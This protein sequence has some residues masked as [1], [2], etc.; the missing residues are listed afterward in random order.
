MTSQSS[1]QVGLGRLFVIFLGLG[2][3]GFGGPV[4]HL[5]M[6][7][8][9]FVSKRQWLSDEAYAERLALCNFMPGPSS[10][11]MGMALGF[12]AQG[13]WGLC[14]AFLGFTLPSAVLMTAFAYGL[15]VVD[16]L[17][18]P[19][20]LLGIKLSVVAIV[21]HA[22]MG[23]ARS[24]CP[25]ARRAGIALAAMAAMIIVPDVR[26]QFAVLAAGAVLGLFFIPYTQQTDDTPSEKYAVSRL[27]P[28]AMCL[29]G[30]FVLL[31]GLPVLARAT[32][33]PLIDLFT[34]FYRVGSLVFG[35]G[36]VVLPLLETETVARGWI[37]WDPFV[38]GYGAAQAVPGP[39]FTFAAYLGTLATPGAEGALGL[40]GAA[41][42]VFGIF[43]PSFFLVSGILPLWPLLR[44]HSI[45]RR[46]LL[47]I[48][49]AVVGLLAAVLYS[50]VMTSAMS[51]ASPALL[52][53]QAGV[54][55]ILFFLLWMSKVPSWAILALG[56]AAGVTLETFA[57]GQ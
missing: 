33:A 25:D 29:V 41:V 36:H 19:G 22:L 11:Q 1:P 2:L 15:T 54:V 39:M 24:L 8:E 3:R 52:A 7:R 31:V 21:A 49:A 14:A 32:D 48:N 40:A 23:M 37:A 55:C 28:P 42:A 16:V 53:V 57:V 17:Q 44:T 18:S 34:V 47:G 27:I 46:L 35:G 10:S 5:A 6:F 56:L 38:A 13:F 50:P 51:A 26:M 43:A 30:F 12:G 9:E 4:A 45:I 20:V